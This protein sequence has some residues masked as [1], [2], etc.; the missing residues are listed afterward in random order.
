MSVPWCRRGFTPPRLWLSEC[1]AP[2]PEW[3]RTLPNG[4]LPDRQDFVHY[5]TDTAARV[6]AWQAATSASGQLAEEFAQWLER[7]D[8]RAVQP[9]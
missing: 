8:M 4:K 6:R 5:G 3:V 2:N 1:T 9:L 7:P